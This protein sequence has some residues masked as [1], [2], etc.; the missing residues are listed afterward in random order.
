MFRWFLL[1]LFT[2]FLCSFA[3]YIRITLLKLQP[4][5]TYT[6]HYTLTMFC[7]FSSPS[8][9]WIGWKWQQNWN[10]SLLIE[11]SPVF[12]VVA[13]AQMFYIY[14]KRRHS[15]E[16]RVYANV[17]NERRIEVI[18]LKYNFSA[19]LQ[20]PTIEEIS[21]KNE[22]RHENCALL[23]WKFKV[24]RYWCMCECVFYLNKLW[25]IWGKCSL[26]WFVHVLVLFI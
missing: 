4:I 11:F 3:M 14:V 5:R 18:S 9:K 16:K 12:R 7:L 10:M 26:V 2:C 13:C 17:I 24:C 20:S 8:R 1:I 19:L 25:W 23:H 6:L 15:L 21:T 22:K